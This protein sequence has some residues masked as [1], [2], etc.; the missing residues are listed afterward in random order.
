MIRIL[1]AAAA[2]LAVISITGSPAQAYGNH[3]WCAVQYTGLFNTEW[4]CEYDAIEAC[5]PHILAGNRG[6]CNLNPYYHA[7][8]RRAVRRHY[9]RRH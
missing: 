7:P 3:P 5:R 1:I 2:V 8:Q 4:N 6:F 9:Y